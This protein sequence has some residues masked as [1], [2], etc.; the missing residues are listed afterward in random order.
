MTHRIRVWDLPTRLFHWVLV[1]CF[2]ASVVTGMVGG[3]AMAWH[4]RSGLLLLCLLLFRLIWGFMGGHWS[5]FASFV[6]RPATVLA[7]IRGQGLPEHSVGHNPLGAGSVLA[8][9]FFLLLQVAS[10]SFSDDEIAFAGPLS[11]FVSN[12]SVSLATSYHK[13]IGKIALLVLVLLHIAAIIYYRVKKKQNLVP[14][15]LHGDKE[16]SHAAQPSRDDARARAL[17]LLVFALCA[18]LVAWGV[19]WAG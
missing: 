17:A 6:H 9:L 4:F 10:G 18:G 15:M 5:R 2:A 1:L 14:P 13:Q 3:G 8:L 16:L 7:Y 12:A 11:K 19:Q